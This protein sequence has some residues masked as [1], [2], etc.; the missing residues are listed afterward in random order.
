MPIYDGKLQK[1]FIAKRHICQM[2][3][4]ANFSPAYNLPNI[5]LRKE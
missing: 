2:S 5:R 3:L 4:N 1:Y